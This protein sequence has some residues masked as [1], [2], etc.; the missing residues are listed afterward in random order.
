MRDRDKQRIVALQRGI[1]VAREALAKV[2]QMTHHS[3]QL[4]IIH[5]AQEDIDKLDWNSKPDLVQDRSAPR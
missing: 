2:E 3:D 1:R 4:A 5:Q